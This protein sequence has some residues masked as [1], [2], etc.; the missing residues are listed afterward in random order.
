M[1]EVVHIHEII[2]CK[3]LEIFFFCKKHI[4]A[5]TDPGQEDQATSSKKVRST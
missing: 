3:D 4:L 5:V 1:N 2:D